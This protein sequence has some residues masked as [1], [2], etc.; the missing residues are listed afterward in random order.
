MISTSE[1]TV[2]N[3]RRELEMVAEGRGWQVVITLADEGIS[4]S[5]RRDKRAAFDRFC[6]GI[7][8]LSARGKQQ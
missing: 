2:E 8:G 5:K 7:S 6:K 4:G 1:Q 3:Y